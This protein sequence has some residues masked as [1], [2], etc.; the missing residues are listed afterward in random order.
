MQFTLEQV[1]TL[2]GMLAGLAGVWIESRVRF[3]R[4]EVRVGIIWK[5][6]MRRAVSE[7]V[8]KGIASLNSPVTIRDEAKKWM[9]KMRPELQAF[10]RRLG[11]N[12]TPDELAMEIERR[13]GDEILREVCIPNGL[14][15][16]AC[17]LI[18]REVA[19]EG[20]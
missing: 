3:A 10:Y 15:E 4:L 20:P 11:R 12:L 6:L 19:R 17:L 18:A 7:S 13:F 5:S 1:L 14:S 16:H 9:D 2:L 8:Q